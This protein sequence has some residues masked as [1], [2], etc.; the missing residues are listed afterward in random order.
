MNAAKNLMRHFLRLFR[1]RKWKLPYAAMTGCAACLALAVSAFAASPSRPHQCPGLPVTVAG[2]TAS[3]AS[4]V[5]EG[6][7]AAIAFFASQGLAIPP[8][9]RVRVKERLPPAVPSTAL[10]WFSAT[11]DTVFVLPYSRFRKSMTWSNLPRNRRVYVGVAIHEVAHALGRFN[12]SV[13]RPSVLAAEYVAYVAMLSGMD[14]ATRA[15][16]L[17]A[18]SQVGAQATELIN[19]ALYMFDP[20]GFGVRAYRHYVELEDGPAFF[21]DV[22]SGKALNDY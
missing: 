10:G 19:P 7:G 12:S 16:V 9:V 20:I 8:T 1:A 15:R 11:E 21:R 3:D 2:A 14:S 17:H 22:L 6:A 13:A 5:C 4:S 18:Y